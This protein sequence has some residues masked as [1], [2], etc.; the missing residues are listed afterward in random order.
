[1]EEWRCHWAKFQQYYA[2]FVGVTQ[3]S[4]EHRLFL[5]RAAFPSMLVDQY[6]GPHSPNWKGYSRG[7]IGV[8]G[9]RV[10]VLSSLL[11]HKTAGGQPD[12]SD[13]LLALAHLMRGCASSPESNDLP[14]PPTGYGCFLY[15]LDPFCLSYYFQPVSFRLLQYVK[16]VLECIEQHAANVL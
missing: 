13:L 9:M 3:L 11:T 10:M 16:H 14:P 8:S 1:M 7:D 5:N 6:M 4:H 12:L 2:I 15:D